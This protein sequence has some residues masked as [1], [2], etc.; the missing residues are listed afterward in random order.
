MLASNLCAASSLVSDLVMAFKRL[1]MSACSSLNASARFRVASTWSLEAMVAIERASCASA[2][3]YSSIRHYQI[4][5]ADKAVKL[6]AYL[7]PLK[8]M[9][10]PE[11]A[12]QRVQVLKVRRDLDLVIEIVFDSRPL[13]RRQCRRRRRHGESVYRGWRRD[14]RA[15]RK[16]SSPNDH[17]RLRTG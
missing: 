3:Y 15:K 17:R 13:M 9:L 7:L 5:I 2:S 10:G 16:V 8:L 1:S 11:T 12:E 14:S 4:R 6:E